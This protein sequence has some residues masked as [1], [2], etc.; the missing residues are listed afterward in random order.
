MKAFK[1]SRPTSSL[2]V[3]F[4]LEVLL[5]L[6][7]AGCF[8][9]NLPPISLRAEGWTAREFPAV[10]QR[11]S[12]APEVAGD[13]LVAFHTDGTR[14]IQFSKG[15]LP[16][17]S[18]RASEEGWV[19]NSSLRKGTFGGRSSPPNSIVWFQVPTG[20]NPS[21]SV[22]KPPWVLETSESG[23][24]ILRHP[25]SGERLEGLGAP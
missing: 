5:V 16:I 10:W 22:I 2:V 3:C 6:S 24:W 19:L 9:P 8:A 17:L 12:K 1:R 14:Y 4:C 13:L 20:L 15:G 11:S 18:A 7:A 21:P 23:G 25:R